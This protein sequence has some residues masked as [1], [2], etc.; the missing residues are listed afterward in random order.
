M[1]RVPTNGHQ[2]S[3]R[4]NN[5]NSKD[6]RFFAGFCK[7]TQERDN[8]RIGFDVLREAKIET[9]IDFVKSSSHKQNR[10]RL[11]WWSDWSAFISVALLYCHSYQIYDYRSN[12]HIRYKDS[13]FISVALFILSF[14]FIAS[15]VL[16]EDMVKLS[17]E[18]VV[19]MKV[20]FYVLYRTQKMWRKVN[21]CLCICL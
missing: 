16:R 14:F 3:V 12:L 19:K 1:A 10:H 5:I 18:C 8:N 2:M 21:W 13:A 20:A 7:K 6:G 11:P 4:V 17:A 15:Y 9:R